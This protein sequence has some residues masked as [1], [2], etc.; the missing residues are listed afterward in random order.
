VHGHTSSTRARHRVCG[1]SLTSSQRGPVKLGA[2]WRALHA[3]TRAQRSENKKKKCKVCRSCGN[4]MHA[5]TR[6]VRACACSA[7]L[8]KMRACACSAKQ[9]K[10]VR[11]RA[12]LNNAIVCVC[13]QR[14]TMQ[15]ACVCVQRYTM[16]DACVCV[17]R[18][19]M[20]A[21]VL[22]SG[23]SMHAALSQSAAWSQQ[24]AQHIP[25]RC[26]HTNWGSARSRPC[27]T[28]AK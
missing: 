3:G 6:C 25:K 13:V 28:I 8:C 27:L 2:G 1:H 21:F 18:Y 5:A 19:T 10:C 24:H 15:D 23:M 12:A 20:Q 7:T 9:C 4:S 16:Q 22:F 26:D 14:Y 17:Q 11:V